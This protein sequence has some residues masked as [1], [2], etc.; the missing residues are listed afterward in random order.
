M[1][2][3]LSYDWTQTAEDAAVRSIPRRSTT[4]K[5]KLMLFSLGMAAIAMGLSGSAI[6]W[7]WSQYQALDTALMADTSPVQVSLPPEDFADAEVIHGRLVVLTP[8]AYDSRA[9]PAAAQ[10]QSPDL[11]RA[12]EAPVPGT[13]AAEVATPDETA[14]DTAT[15]D[16]DD[17][18]SADPLYYDAPVAEPESF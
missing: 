13:S 8:P 3:A 14:A 1:S 16:V 10:V 12:L 9:V 5:T 18:V 11:V 15:P 2:Y 17:G 4:G 6:A 7:R